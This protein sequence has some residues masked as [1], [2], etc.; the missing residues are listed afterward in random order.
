MHVSDAYTISTRDQINALFC[1]L[2]EGV[3]MF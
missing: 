2:E 1:K 3:N